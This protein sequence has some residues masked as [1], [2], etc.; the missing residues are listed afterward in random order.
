MELYRFEELLQARDQTEL[1]K[2]TQKVI[3]GLG[4][5]YFCYGLTYRR[6][7][8]DEAR[9]FTL[10]NYPE[11][12]LKHYFEQGYVEIDPAVRQS[13]TTT[14][15][16]IWTEE[17]YRRHN[18]IHLRREANAFGVNGGCCLPIHSTWLNGAGMMALATPEDANKFA[19]HVVATLGQ[20]QLLA[21]FFNQAARN[22]LLPDHM[23]FRPIDELTKRE[24]E[25]L[26]F[27]AAGLPAKLIATRMRVTTATINSYYLPAIRRKLGAA[28]TREAVALAIYYRLIQP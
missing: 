2:S 17:Y 28:S 24:I 23:A 22:L 16:A 14:T 5:A 27:A 25:C 4:F 10:G 15:P 8:E 7:D 13:F 19:P 3:E 1:L 21:G 9:Y 12:W 18:V 11:D 6:H 20:G 26:S